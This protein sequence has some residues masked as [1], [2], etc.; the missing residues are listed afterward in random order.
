M[1]IQQHK[2]GLG[3]TFPVPK[4]YRITLLCYVIS[5]QSKHSCFVLLIIPAPIT[6]IQ[7]WWYFASLPAML[8]IRKL[9]WEKL[10]GE[11]RNY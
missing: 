1:Q 9:Y 5:M 4:E 3:L 2:E 7:S 8:A 6:G 11:E 10:P